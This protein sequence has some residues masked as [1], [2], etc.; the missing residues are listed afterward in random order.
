MSKIKITVFFR[1]GNNVQFIAK[2]F[3]LKYRGDEIVGLDWE[4]VNNQILFI[5]LKDI[6]YVSSKRVWW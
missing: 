4:N 6:E 1:S 2:K 5:S 3:N